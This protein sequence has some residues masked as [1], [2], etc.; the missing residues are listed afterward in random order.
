[1]IFP[2]VRNFQRTTVTKPSKVFLLLSLSLSFSLSP[3]LLL[4]CHSVPNTE[5]TKRNLLKFPFYHYFTSN[6]LIIPLFGLVS[7]TKNISAA[8][9]EFFYLDIKFDN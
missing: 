4:W 1:M 8:A 3:T 5:K 6:I 7:F 9:T 2:T